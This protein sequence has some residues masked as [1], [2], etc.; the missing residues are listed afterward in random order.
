MPATKKFEALT[1]F[2]VHE[3]RDNPTRLGSTRLNKALWFADMVAYK[4]TGKAI[5]GD[6]YVKRQHGP[7][8]KHILAAV[9]KLKAKGAMTVTDPQYAYEPRQYI[10]LTE[11]DVSAL[12]EEEL[13]M[14][15]AAVD[16]MCQQ[17]ATAISDDT[18]DIVWRA[19]RLGEEIP[20]KA[21]LAANRGEVTNDVI[22][23]A[24]ASIKEISAR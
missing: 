1:H 7:V 16:V 14:A 24:N 2:I 19:A 18:H 5:T 17:T 12:S 8:P 22:K 23:W 10:S 13:R 11:P 20:L 4:K 15:K 3:C 9:D 6:K 21:S